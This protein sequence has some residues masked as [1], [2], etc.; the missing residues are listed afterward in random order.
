MARGLVLLKSMT[1]RTATLSAIAVEGRGGNA[2]I[3]GG[4]A[5]VPP[6]GRAEPAV[7]VE[8]EPGFVAD[9]A[10]PGR[11]AWPPLVR[12]CVPPALAV[13]PPVAV[14]LPVAVR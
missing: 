4:L 9:P 3:A 10:L 2:A 13:R 1:P 11:P 8:P 7:P 14:L 5:V 6:P 12:P